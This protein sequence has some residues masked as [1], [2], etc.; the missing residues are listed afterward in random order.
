MKK[1]RKIKENRLETPCLR[2]SFLSQY[3]LTKKRR[4]SLVSTR[5]GDGCGGPGGGFGGPGLV[6]EQVEVVACWDQSFT[7]WGFCCL[8]RS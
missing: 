2:A 5:P 4:C 3:F 1:T 6:L 8:S 7:R